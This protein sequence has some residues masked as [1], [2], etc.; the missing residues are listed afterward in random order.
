[1]GKAATEYSDFAI[2]TS[3]NPRTEDPQ[4]I[5]DDVIPGIENSNYE[6]FIDRVEAIQT[7]VNRA[8]QDDTLLIA[9]KGAE[10]YQEIGTTRHP[11]SDTD[12]IIKALENRG[13]R[14]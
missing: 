9:G 6:V 11:F 12:E 14:G 5:L 2:L 7:I 13:F 8:A 3:D 1:M 10:D 4:A